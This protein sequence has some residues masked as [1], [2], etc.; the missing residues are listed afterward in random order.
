VWANG[1]K[2]VVIVVGPWNIPLAPSDIVD[3]YGYNVFTV[4]RQRWNP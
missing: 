2:S 3:L 4:D 1:Q